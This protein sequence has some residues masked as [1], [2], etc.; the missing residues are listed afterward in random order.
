MQLREARGAYILVAWGE[1]MTRRSR[2]G[3]GNS[4]KAEPPETRHAQPTKRRAD[5]ANVEKQH[6]PI[7][8]WAKFAIGVL[9]T[10]L[11]GAL[12]TDLYPGIKSDL[13]RKPA[14]NFSVRMPQL[15]AWAV[16]V[17]DQHK[18]Q[19]LLGS[20]NGCSSLHSAARSAGGVPDHESDISLLA[21]GNTAGGVTIT[22]IHARIIR[23]RAPLNGAY[24]YCQSAGDEP[25]GKVS[26][27]L[28]EQVSDAMTGPDEQPGKSSL[29]ANGSV[30]HL[31][32]NETFPF[33]INAIVSNSDV[34]WVIDATIVVNGHQSV[35]TIDNHGEPFETTATL[36]YSTYGD[37]YEYDWAGEHRLLHMRNKARNPDD[38][39]ADLA[40]KS[41]DYRG[42]GTARQ[43]L[44]VDCAGNAVHVE[45]WL[46]GSQCVTHH[47][48]LH[49]EARWVFFAAK[50]VCPADTVDTFTIGALFTA[51][52][53]RH[54]GGNPQTFANAFGPSII[55]LAANPANPGPYDH[56]RQMSVG[57]LAQRAD[58]T[59]TL[60]LDNIDTTVGASSA[61]RCTNPGPV[62]FLITF[63]NASDRNNFVYS[64]QNRESVAGHEIGSLRLAAIGPAW[65]VYGT[66]I[67][68]N[69]GNESIDGKSMQQFCDRFGAEN[70][71]TD[72]AH[73]P[74]IYG[75]EAPTIANGLL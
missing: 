59:G 71:L 58:C 34:Q 19:P 33:D 46:P 64:A 4:R 40:R 16:T 14:V 36:P 47:L 20:I 55:S 21:Q 51:A 18:L 70:G 67:F 3:R 60:S 24:T 22:D 62:P 50:T 72:L 66:E 8:N 1:G 41:L 32:N 61:A 5:S 12:V 11:I 10:A 13:L 6:S 73:L 9:V 25:A 38:C 49:E 43:I 27:N 35:I 15:E 74:G 30:V 17:P 23:R 48:G 56:P 53:I 75:N 63:R 37:L 7:P 69:S 31:N 44:S 68:D 42:I 2:K 29:F 57:E 39:S 45:D 52:T 65:L 54:A 26:F 28:N